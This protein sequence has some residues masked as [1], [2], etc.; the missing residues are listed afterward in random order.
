MFNLI[1]NVDNRAV[2]RDLS[3]EKRVIF[4]QRV[5]YRCNRKFKKLYVLRMKQ[6]KG[7][8]LA[9]IDK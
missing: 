3:H 8:K 2:K 4:V 1:Y 6:R 5:N 9:D 7:N